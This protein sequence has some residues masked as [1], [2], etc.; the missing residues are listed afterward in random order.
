MSTKA[1]TSAA[2]Y[3]PAFCMVALPFILL[4]WPVTLGHVVVKR[5]ERWEVWYL[6]P[7]LLLLP[8]L[9]PK[10]LLLLP[11]IIK[12]PLQ[13]PDACCQILTF[14]RWWWCLVFC[15]LYSS[16]TCSVVDT[17][18]DLRGRVK[19]PCFLFISKWQYLKPVGFICFFSSPLT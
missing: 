16:Y 12:Q 11:V 19:L 15:V 1:S 8:C 7:L 18:W 17:Q 10:P 9:C 2:A 14:S 4:R 5:F 3:S 6:S 13:H